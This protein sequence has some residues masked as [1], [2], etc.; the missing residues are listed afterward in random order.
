MKNRRRNRWIARAAIQA[1]ILIGLFVPSASAG[2]RATPPA[3]ISLA[4]TWM[5]RLDPGKVGEEN[6]WQDSTFR[7]SLK[8]PGSLTES[9]I[10]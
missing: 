1:A 10:G 2:N 3:Q 6:R 5:V 4:G 8:L 9:N 7:D